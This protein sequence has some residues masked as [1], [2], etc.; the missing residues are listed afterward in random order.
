M[1]VIGRLL[2]RREPAP[3]TRDPMEFLTR[4][5]LVQLQMDRVRDR[6][7]RAA[8]RGDLDGCRAARAEGEL[9]LENLRTIREEQLAEELESRR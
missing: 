6:A 4:A 1:S 2:Q 7:E 8:E 9:L 3:P 5:R